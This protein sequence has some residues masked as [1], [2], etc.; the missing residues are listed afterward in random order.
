MAA[1]GERVS[2]CGGA[3]SNL[4]GV[5]PSSWHCVIAAGGAAPEPIAQATGARTKGAVSLAG[6]T[7]L[8]RVLDAC[9]G[10]GFESIAIVADE[11]TIRGLDLREGERVVQPGETNIESTLN[12]LSGLPDH[13]PTFLTPCDVP[14]MEPGH[15]R[16]FL[17]AVEER[18]RVAGDEARWFAVGLADEPDVRQRYPGVP[19]RYVKFREGRFAAGA[20]YAS[21]PAS[22]RQAA[23]QLGVGSERRKSVPSLVLQVGLLSLARYL[24]GLVSLAEAERRIG[25]LLGGE[26]S[27]V[28]GC[29]PATTMDFDTL[30]E[31]RHVERLLREQERG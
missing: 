29:D 21:A 26:C 23:Q 22:V 20:L 14:L 16:L 6:S 17:Q 3:S 4:G 25:H 5:T 28:T 13:A 24:L 1:H 7:S 2:W 10:A 12:G 8:A 19:Y 11:N 15:I 18:R 30:D 9:R 31:L 27:I